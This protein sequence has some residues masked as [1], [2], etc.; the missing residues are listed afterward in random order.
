MSALSGCSD[1]CPWLYCESAFFY[2]WLHHKYLHLSFVVGWVKPNGIIT[3][4]QISLYIVD[5]KRL[6]TS[7]IM[8]LS[9]AFCTA[10]LSDKSNM[11][12]PFFNIFCIFAIITT[13]FYLFRLE[14][15]TKICY[16]VNDSIVLHRVFT[17]SV[18][19]ILLLAVTSCWE[20]S[21]RFWLPSFFVSIELL[22]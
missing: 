11:I 8:L 20:L 18:F 16:T 1:D 6:I 22:T 5:L 7:F 9:G 13:D 3:A 21:R 19:S 4:K 15:I 12:C 10:G 2:L 17:R 14:Y